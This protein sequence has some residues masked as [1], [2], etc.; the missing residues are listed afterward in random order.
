MPFFAAG[1]PR[2]WEKMA[3]SFKKAA[4]KSY[5]KPVSGPVLETIG[6]LAKAV[7]GVW[8]S[9]ETPE[10]VRSLLVIPFGFFKALAYRKVR[11]ASG[12]DRATF[13]F[14]GAAP[15]PMD[16]VNYL[17][18]L[19]MPLL[20][21]FGMSESCGAI[22]VSG[23]NDTIRPAGSCG[24]ALPLGNLVIA[25]D[26][27]VLWSGDNTM[28]AYKGLPEATAAAVDSKTLQLRT[29]DLGTVDS[30][31]YLKITGRK[32]DLIITAGGENIAPVPIEETIMG[33]LDGAA[34]H[35]LL[36]GDHRKFLTILVA[37]NEDTRQEIKSES[38]EKA[39]AA[40]NSSFAQSRAQRVQKAHVVA[41][42]FTVATGELTPTLKAKRSVIVDKYSKEIDTLYS[43]GALKLVGYSSMNI[44]RPELS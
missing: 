21:V 42:P 7:G 1:V 32:K 4:Q 10:L 38:V 19:D 22:A 43:D 28:R 25:P 9:P 31:G 20:E 30:H 44:D 27:E 23:P 39:I 40:Y 41:S 17:R 6:S 11:R 8:Y 5:D 3:A 16:T 12:L 35:V 34:G 2:V 15:L 37:P 29:G 13:L 33:L 24:P 18:S 36:I 26:G 14:T